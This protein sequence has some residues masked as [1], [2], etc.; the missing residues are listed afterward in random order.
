MHCNLLSL[1]KICKSLRKIRKECL[2][3]KAYNNIEAN[4]KLIVSAFVIFL[5]YMLAN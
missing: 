4:I 1:N 2:F 5:I 3:I